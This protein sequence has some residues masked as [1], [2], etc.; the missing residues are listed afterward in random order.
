LSFA[1][2]RIGPL[3][4][5]VTTVFYLLALYLLVLPNTPKN[6]FASIY[7]ESLIKTTHQHLLLLVGFD[8]LIYQKYYDTPLYLWVINVQR[9]QM[10]ESIGAIGEH[11]L[12]GGLAVENAVERGAI[13]IVP[14]APNAELVEVKGEL[15]KI[16][17]Q[18][19]QL[20][21]LKKQANLMADCFF[22]LYNCDR[23]LIIA[24]Q[25]LEVVTRDP[26]LQ[27]HY[28]VTCICSYFQS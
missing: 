19:R 5:I 10:Q 17:K 14:N 12:G 18:L 22:L 6:L 11:N 9:L 24:H 26:L 20:I 7:S 13:L 1:E 21:E 27:I 16:N 25:A 4:A 28:L 8:T 15:N 23:I 3:A 2:E